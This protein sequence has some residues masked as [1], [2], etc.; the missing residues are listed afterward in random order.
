MGYT[1]HWQSKCSTPYERIIVATEARKPNMSAIAE[2][3]GVS[4]MTVSRIFKGDP[5]VSASTR[6]LVLRVAEKSGFIP[7]TGNRR[8]EDSAARHYYVVFTEDSSVSDAYFSEIILSIQQ[9]L[10]DHGCGCSLGIVNEN[11]SDFVKL[12]SML[13]PKTTAGVIIVGDIQIDYANM[14]RA[15]FANVVFVDY[16]GDPGITGPYQTVC[17]D[18]LYGA[19]MA[20]RHLLGLG[21]I[22]ILLIC[23]KEGHYFSTDLLRAYEEELSTRC[24]ELDR[25]LIAFADFHAD[26]G[27]Q[28]TMRVL[29]AGRQFDAVFTNDEMACGA[30]KALQEHGVRIPEDVSVV[31]FDGLPIGAAVNPA[32]TTVV[33]DRARMG[34]IAVEQL[35]ERHT[36]AN[37]TLGEKISLFPTML[38]RQSCGGKVSRSVKEDADNQ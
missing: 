9:Q 3:C 2:M 30:M 38:V 24:I 15:S 31:G 8:S 1:N 28:A 19:H 13:R 21:R 23:G 16:P 6:E 18:Q 35:L 5:N 32:L 33:V 37:A 29:E 7:P 26:G 14:L 17:T 36:Q 22:R 25:S 12:H 10:F 11:Y 34:R 4:K 27:Y 20:M